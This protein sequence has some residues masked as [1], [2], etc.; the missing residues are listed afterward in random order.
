[1]R[2][3]VLERE[4]DVGGL[5]RTEQFRGYRFDLGGHRF[6]TKWREVDTFWRETLGNDF[7]RR[8]RLSRIHFKGRFFPYPLQVA[9]TLRGSEPSSPPGWP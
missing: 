8:P 4:P 6:Y 1:M 5:A 7:I 9:A 3:L 2:P